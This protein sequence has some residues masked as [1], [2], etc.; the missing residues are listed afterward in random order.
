MIANKVTLDEL[1]QLAAQLRP[2][3]QIKLI[4]NISERLSKMR[5]PEIEDED[6]RQ[7]YAAQ[8]EAF[9]KFSD[10]N[11]AETIGDVDSAREIRQIRDERMAKL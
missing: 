10:E 8:I 1:V 3:E 4:A 6:G 2:Q 11:A 7:D 9:L 5:L